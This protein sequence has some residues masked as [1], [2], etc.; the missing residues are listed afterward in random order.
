MDRG[1]WLAAVHGVARVGHDLPT[2]QPPPRS[3]IPTCSSPTLEDQKLPP[4]RWKESVR[5]K[6]PKVLDRMGEEELSTG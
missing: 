3:L 1:A 5:G 4:A 2:K 6:K